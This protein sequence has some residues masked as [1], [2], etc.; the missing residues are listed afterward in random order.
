MV[1]V[2]RAPGTAQSSVSKMWKHLII[3][4]TIG[5]GVSLGTHFRG[6]IIMWEPDDT[7]MAIKVHFRISWRRS[8]SSHYY[9]DD[10]IISNRTLIGTDSMTCFSGC[11]GNVGSLQFL[12][13]DYNTGNDD[14][15]TGRNTITY[16]PGVTAFTFGY[17]GCCWIS[18]L[19]YGKD[20][21][22]QFQATV[23]MSVRNDTE[24]INRSPTVEMAPIVVLLSGCTYTIQLPVGDVDGDI[25]RCRWASTTN[26]CAGV[27]NAIPGATINQTQCSITYSAYTVGYYAVAVQIEDFRSQISTIPLSSIPL[28]FL[29]HVISCTNCTCDSAPEFVSPTPR[30]DECYAI[31][32]GDQFQVSITARS[33]YILRS[34]TTITA[35]GMRRSTATQ[36]T[37]GT[38][39]YIFV[40]ITWAPT[41]SDGGRDHS[42]C[43]YA[44]DNNIGISS[45]AQCIR[46]A[47][48]VPGP[49]PLRV[50]RVALTN[51]WVIVI[52]K[53]FKRPNAS[54]FI[55]VYQ[56]STDTLVES[57]DV[58]TSS[59]VVYDVNYRRINVTLSYP[60]DIDTH[61][62]VILPP[63]LVEGY[64]SCGALSVA[65]NNTS[66]WKIELDCGPLT[67][68]N[69]SV[70]APNGTA[71]PASINYV[72]N[73][74]FDLMRNNTRTC[75]ANRTWTGY[76]P[77]CQIR[78]CGTFQ[79]PFNGHVSTRSTVYNTTVLFTCDTGYTINGSS[80]MYCNASGTWS[81]VAPVCN[82]VNCGSP[83][84]L[85]DGFVS[86]PNG[87]TF[88]EQAYYSCKPGFDLIGQQ[89]RMCQANSIWTL[90]NTS[91]VPKDCGPINSPAN[92]NINLNGTT[93]GNIISYTCIFGH[94]LIG[95]KSRVCLA[96]GVW[97]GSDPVCTLK[98]CG[99][100]PAPSHGSV[101]VP[102][103]LYGSYAVYEC[104]RG[105]HIDG[106]ST[107]K[108]EA[109]G[110]WTL[111]IPTCTLTD[112][113]HLTSPTHGSVSFNST[114][115]DDCAVFSCHTGYDVIGNEV[116]C[117]Q[118]N[119]TWTSSKTF[120]SL[121]DCGTPNQPA[122]GRMTVNATTYL[123]TTVFSCNL[124]YS[125]IGSQIL[126]CQANGTWNALEPVCQIRDC[127]SLL[128]PESGS[129]SYT[130]S[131]YQSVARYDCNTGYAMVGN[132]TRF[133][134]SDAT[135]S[136][137]PPFCQIKD[138]RIP[139]ILLNGT[140]AF[141]NTTFG[142]TVLYT[143]DAG[144]D[145][146]G[147]NVSECLEFGNWSSPHT[148]CRIKDCGSLPP[149][150]NGVATI[151]LTVFGSTTTYSCEVG[152]DLMGSS[153]LLCEANGRWN[154]SV[155]TCKI[156]ECSHLSNPPDG[157][158]TFTSITYRSVATYTCNIGFDLIGVST[159]EC[160]NNRSWSQEI[161]FCKIKDC[162][163]PHIPSHGSVL[164]N[165]TT[166]GALSQYSCNNGYDLVGS[167]MSTCTQFGNWSAPDIF[168]QIKDC[169]PLTGLNNG[170]VS[171][172][173]TT[174]TELA[175]YICDTGYDMI[176]N[177]TRV[178]QATGTW[179]G[180]PP[181]CRIKDCGQ[182]PPPQ[183]GYVYQPLTTYGAFALFIC[184][185][186]YH[187][188][189]PFMI[190]RFCQADGTW[191]SAS[192]SCQLTDCG[193]LTS[194]V[195]G[196]VT[197]NGTL[198][199][200][201]A[202]YSCNTGYDIIGRTNVCCHENATWTSQNTT[203]RLKDCGP[204]IR[205]VNG[206]MTI[207]ATTFLSVSEFTCDEGYDLIG[208]ES[209]VCRTD[210]TWND[211]EPTCR[212]RDC[213]SLLAPASGTVV[214][215]RS[216][217]GSVAIY[218]CNT[219]HDMVGNGTR[220]CLS[221]ATWSG[222][223]PVCQI[224]DCQIPHIPL[225]GTAAFSNTT[226]GSSVLYTCD[227]G[228]D[229]IGNNVSE[230]LEFGN[231]SSLHSHCQIK[232]CGSVPPPLNGVTTIGPTVFGS[233]IICTCDIG[234]DLVGSSALFC[235]ANGRWNASAP[236]CR[237][238]ECSY[239]IHPTNGQVIFINITF[240]SMATYICNIGFELIG[241]STR[242][243]LSNTSW[244][245]E[246]PVCKIK[247]CGPPH[248]PSNGNV[249]GNLTTYGSLSHYSC[250][251]GYDL[252]RGNMSTCTQYGNWS[253]PDIFCQIKDCGPLISPQKCHVSY[254]NTTYTERAYFS[255]ETGY[256]IIGNA[257][258]V[259]QA[260]GTWSGIPPSCH[261]K[262]CGG[263]PAPLNGKV[264]QPLT[265]YG[266]YA[267]FVCDEGYHIVPDRMN[268]RQCLANG[269][270][271]SVNPSCKLTD[272]GPLPTPQHG[273]V[274]F[275]S[276]LYGALASVSCDVGYD[277]AGPETVT[278]TTFE[279]W[280]YVS[281]SC[282]IKDCGPIER[283]SNGRFL[284]NGTTYDSFGMF[285]CYEGYT[286]VGDSSMFCQ[287]TGYWNGT[288]P[289][290]QIKECQVPVAPS[291]GN[292]DYISVHFGSMVTYR[293][294]A[295]YTL[296]GDVSR[297]CGAH[298]TWT[299]ETPSCVIKDCGSPVHVLN[300]LMVFNSTTYLSQAHI[301][302][303]EGFDLV[304][305]K[306]VV[307]TQDGIWNDSNISCRIKD[308]G[309]PSTPKH[310]YAAYNDT[311]FG[312]QIEVKCNTGY[313]ISS[314]TFGEC[315]YNGNWSY[316][317]PVCTI[318]DCEQLSDIDH[319][320]VTFTKTTFGETA[321]YS[322]NDGYELNG[323]TTR[324]CNASGMWSGDKPVC[325]IADCFP[326]VL[327]VNG[328]ANGNN[329]QFGG[330]VVFT[331]DTGYTLVGE[332]YTYCQA[333]K[334]WSNP[335]P[336]CEIM[337]CGQPLAPINGYA[338]YNSTTFGS[339]IAVKCNTGYEI[340]SSTI[341]ECDYT[342]N[343][344]Y[345]SP[346]CTIKDCGDI[347]LRTVGN[348]S[349][350]GTTYGQ[351]A[352][353]TC[354]LGYDAKHEVIM[355][356][357]QST[358]NGTA[359][360]II[361]DCGRL[362]SP[363]NGALELNASTYGSLASTSCNVGYD[364]V[365]VPTLSCTSNG[366]WS[367]TLA[368][369]VIKDCGVIQAIGHGSVIFNTTTFES[370]MSFLCDEGF[371]LVGQQEVR[372]TEHGHW[373]SVM[374]FCKQA[375]CGKPVAVA[376]SVYE[377]N[378]T[379][380]G[381]FVRYS[382]NAGYRL[383]GEPVSSCFLNEKWSQTPICTI[384]EC[385][386]L[387][388]P[389]SGNATVSSTT[390]GSSAIY[391]CNKGYHLV[392]NQLRTCLQNGTWSG[393]KPSCIPKDCGRLFDPANGKVFFNNTTF[394]AKA[395]FSCQEGYVMS[396]TDLVTCMANGSWS[397]PFPDCS[398]A[399]CGNLTAPDHGTLY[400]NSTV[401]GSHAHVGCNDGYTLNGPELIA[402]SDNGTWNHSMVSCSA[403]DCGEVDE[404]INGAKVTPYS[405]LFDSTIGFVCNE[406]YVL[407]GNEQLYCTK[408]GV[409]NGGPPTCEVQAYHAA[410]IGG[411]VGGTMGVLLLFTVGVIV[412][413]VRGNL[414]RPSLDFE[415]ISRKGS[416]MVEAPFQ[417]QGTRQS[418]FR[419]S[420]NTTPSSVYRPAK[421]WQTG[422]QI[423][424]QTY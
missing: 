35:I 414:N 76:D 89:S 395:V 66:F 248:I 387:E 289:V 323:A 251:T 210:G 99:S 128:A 153:A 116:V 293:C 315:D 222:Q 232:N 172:V 150:L 201:C 300:S 245:D 269:T 265:T 246:E 9:C 75:Q 49:I 179:S 297:T 234:Y 358:W 361:K 189:P 276:T 165:L 83:P 174:Y 48:S 107:R 157:N 55:E 36:S 287:E 57:V 263:L 108:C 311:I 415:G 299:G 283:P 285:I 368:I 377:T 163:P 127:G 29:V 37:D 347:S 334:T 316:I 375:D 207:K 322:C 28:Q 14:W 339:Q 24:L 155:P 200:N 5:F 261:I 406:G 351:A 6:A 335:T 372:C 23:D 53:S 373:S 259:C 270:W 362:S 356:T 272:C 204:L 47:V 130:S 343:W 78:D 286:L 68:G 184:N 77:F 296:V 249:S 314:T 209:L 398:I 1:N 327:P 144:F 284:G 240:A 217:Y 152:Y 258:R 129:V 344:S 250:N 33:K 110:K 264:I 87:T 353:I 366:Q 167:S 119:G 321:N 100:L 54:A 137:Q 46:I 151:G 117:C 304:G 281:H 325:V 280:S 410:K 288:T 183:N 241:V 31:K 161:P 384:L 197:H 422:Y 225:N 253:A 408:E 235:E 80:T 349:Y 308:C 115:L 326:L 126:L 202:A 67:L 409:W 25:V 65:I 181:S 231:W 277:M 173:N 318:K 135:W 97:S 146:I 252:V 215:A 396:G 10:T 112:C 17:T 363:P 254:V 328:Q 266:S 364:L 156:R 382:C 186:G 141:S 123:G 21:S 158:M 310:G 329:R 73:P 397:I 292:V 291:N 2:T 391:W 59:D 333:N 162:G 237:I 84:P 255:A 63:G 216:T 278:C 419:S 359:E 371:L 203:C 312:S 147:N 122:N 212:I 98:D 109:D 350:N 402:C 370:K 307:C 192:P 175:F 405:T 148:W 11:T 91:C 121:K 221:N 378:G 367:N 176:G 120:C 90:I 180:S 385:G 274:F 62:H 142:S 102:V 139:P 170:H 381:S 71:Y 199:D 105:Y 369:C 421:M 418:L 45:I 337:D 193:N 218:Q 41:A 374:P 169:G 168:C 354:P 393:D 103:T 32:V 357:K 79:L 213:G 355:C 205:P 195:N 309:Q 392:G 15:T 282:T 171:Y 72:C 413:L 376:N 219:G 43:F 295:G 12:C 214:Y 275:N 256:Y 424:M 320:I 388:V 133:C 224:K 345:N 101:F 227:A 332:M 39:N 51:L 338:V 298:A 324:H 94:A 92:G 401:Y 145:L 239:L 238:R 106:I 403:R 111:P 399:D 42:L 136:G 208:S 330:V 260:N 3:L 196:K 303:L 160:L 58:A 242:E 86:T 220:D 8:Y 60:Y 125:L 243:C 124:G 190:T 191:A 7:G 40:N 82:I 331:C 16:T 229:L 233:L 305:S 360:C 70:L 262:D 131:I 113:G 177:A 389:D 185:R 380:Y 166:Y 206:H 104:V 336:K 22:W 420:V 154:A 4:F 273:H 19:V 279:Q 268:N 341:G 365:G 383:V 412:Y 56:T 416:V 178:C 26:E 188:M 149:P 18:T 228:F 194:P 404:P 27:C 407:T 30:S 417:E 313:E 290:C 390:F 64:V 301:A 85:L 257:T 346:V 302:C 236:T 88:M 348:I 140:A 34:V 223:P 317:S 118:K 95:D 61:Y 138:C 267:L 294:L 20:S 230:C 198:L 271:G 44:T 159:R 81:D 96:S 400:M 187:I 38:W 114:L 411:A 93:F 132:G 340:S 306:L 74:G 244:S 13:T 134:L 50:E 182:L 211:T 164:G 226:F 352:V 319:G 143:C 342:G 386:P 423:P 379:T 247:D 69:G 394:G 52:D